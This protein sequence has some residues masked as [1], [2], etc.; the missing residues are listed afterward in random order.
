MRQSNLRNKCKS[1]GTQ[2]TATIAEAP[3]EFSARIKIS[4][5]ETIPGFRVVKYIGPVSELS[6]ASG[7]SAS[8]KG[9]S[10]LSRALDGLSSSASSLGG[11]AIVGLQASAFGAGGGI[12]NML[13]GDAVGILLIGT[14]VVVEALEN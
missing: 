1:C 5:T 9:N 3:I 11:N 4:S 12:T 6:S 13:G 14:C 7:W 8:S 2:F 10:A